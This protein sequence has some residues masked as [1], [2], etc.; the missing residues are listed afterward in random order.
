MNNIEMNRMNGNNGA[1]AGAPPKQFIK[2]T[3]KEEVITGPGQQFPYP[4]NATGK[5]L[6]NVNAMNGKGKFF[7]SLTSRQAETETAAG[8]PVVYKR[9][10]KMNVENPK[11]RALQTRAAVNNLSG[12]FGRMGYGGKSK[13]RHTKRR[14]TRRRHTKHRHTRRN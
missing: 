13:R 9:E 5:L 7:H 1:P 12:M 2:K 11:W 8:R 4:I 3:I 6:K 10:Y 14:S